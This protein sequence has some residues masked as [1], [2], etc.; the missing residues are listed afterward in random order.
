LS[1]PK[2]IIRRAKK[3]ETQIKAKKVFRFENFKVLL[4]GKAIPKEEVFCLFSM[5]KFVIWLNS[6]NLKRILKEM[7]K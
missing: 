2:D 7:K 4:G 5:K 3:I 1:N 6:S